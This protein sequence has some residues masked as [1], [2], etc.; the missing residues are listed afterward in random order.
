MGIEFLEF[1]TDRENVSIDYTDNDG[2]AFPYFALLYKDD[3][4]YQPITE[5]NI[6]LHP[7]NKIF[8]WQPPKRLLRTLKSTYQLL[9]DKQKLSN[10]LKYLKMELPSLIRALEKAIENKATE[11][12]IGPPNEPYSII[13]EA[14]SNRSKCRK[15]YN[16]IPK[17]QLRYGEINQ[18]NGN[19]N[20]YHL[21]CGVEKGKNFLKALNKYPTKILNKEKLQKTAQKHADKDH[22]RFEYSLSSRSKCI[23]CGNNI[24]KDSLRVCSTENIETTN[25]KKKVFTH[26]KCA[27][28]VF[29]GYRGLNSEQLLQFI[30]DQ[31]DKRAFSDMDLKKAVKDWRSVKL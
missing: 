28:F 29:E 31:S 27:P 25:I 23:F 6:W 3:E 24:D 15:C 2:K 8:D 10:E 18:I 13:E 9:K 30:L 14:R 19:Y 17:G 16:V 4:V 26:P 11:V 22:P 20:W 21:E 5:S 7:L 12:R 1:E